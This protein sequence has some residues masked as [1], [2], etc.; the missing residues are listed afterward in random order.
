MT[1]LS[2]SRMAGSALR[3]ALLIGLTNGCYRGDPNIPQ[4]APTTG[5]V[6][7]K[8]TPLAGAT[9]SFISSDPDKGNLPGVGSTDTEGEYRIQ[10]Y[11]RDGAVVGNH[12]VVI[13][14]IDENSLARDPKSGAPLPRMH[15]KWKPPVSR[16]PDRYGHPE[17]SKL[18]AEVVESSSNQFDFHLEDK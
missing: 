4:L 11:N 12:K 2:E 17:S 14:A 9:I 18:T 15:P 16:I 5:I 13:V 7:Y 8:G 6:T 10:T 3:V 1:T